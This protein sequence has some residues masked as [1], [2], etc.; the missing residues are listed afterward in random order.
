MGPYPRVEPLVTQPDGSAIPGTPAPAGAA[1]G[2]GAPGGGRGRAGGPGPDANAAPAGGRGAGNPDEGG[3]P[4]ARGGRGPARG[5]ANSAGAGSI[6]DAN[7]LYKSKD[8]EMPK[9]PIGGQNAKGAG[10]SSSDT[11]MGTG[12]LHI[13]HFAAVLRE[14]GF[15][16]P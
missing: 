3:G 13:P 9:R 8:G 7:P 12:A 11:A 5:P 10:W 16:G 4:P 1:G 6:D 2:R 15:N 14:I